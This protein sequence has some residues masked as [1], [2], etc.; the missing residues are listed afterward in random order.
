[1][2]DEATPNP[3]TV[4]PKPDYFNS[5][6]KK[7]WGTLQIIA[8]AEP[9]RGI[10]GEIKAFL[11]SESAKPTSQFKPLVY[12]PN[13]A[14]PINP[15]NWELIGENTPYLDI[16]FLPAESLPE[17]YKIP[18]P[19]EMEGYIQF[20]EA[21]EDH[22]SNPSYIRA[23]RRM[24]RGYIPSLLGLIDRLQ[25]K[26][27]QEFAYIIGYTNPQMAEF[28]VRALGFHYAFKHSSAKQIELSPEAKSPYVIIQPSELIAQK[29]KLEKIMGK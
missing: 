11:F 12:C 29:G 28:A 20:E 7:L 25:Q 16:H 23:S 18:D 21:F 14:N 26:E 8:P 10:V 27:N 19:D 17:G 6:D 9:D 15:Q 1:M 4:E 22:R 24:L 5:P 13:P 3:I 2:F